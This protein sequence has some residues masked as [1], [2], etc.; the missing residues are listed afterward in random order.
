MAKGAPGRPA[1]ALN[2]IGFSKKGDIL[3]PATAPRVEIYVNGVALNLPEVPTR[4]NDINGYTGYDRY[5][6]PFKLN[7]DKTPEVSVLTSSNANDVKVEIDQPKSAKDK[8]V[9]RVDWKGKVKT[10]TLIPQ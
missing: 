6:V 1:V 8:A 2:G 10:Y 7:T 5:D 9:V 4:S 3:S